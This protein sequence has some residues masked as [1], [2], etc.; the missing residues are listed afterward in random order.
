MVIVYDD[1][2]AGT[3][4]IRT[5]EGARRQLGGGIEL[6]PSLWR[7]DLLEDPD[8]RAAA[9][10]EAVQAGLVIISTSSKG[11]LPAAVG[12]GSTSASGHGP[13]PWRLGGAARPGG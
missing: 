13:A 6:Y 10:A 5:L 12:T 7:F 9:T 8:W 1:A 4:A 3:R 11:E 2:P